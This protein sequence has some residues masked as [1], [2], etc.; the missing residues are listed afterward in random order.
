MQCR[1]S[2]ALLQVV[3]GHAGA[4][5]DREVCGLLFG[6]AERIEDAVPAANVSAHPTDS[7]ELDPQALFAAVRAERMGGRRS[8]GH[9]HSHPNG[10]ASPSPR[11]AAASHGDGR[12]WLII[13]ENGVRAW[14]AVRGGAVEGAFEP[15]ELVVD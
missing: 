12:V 3:L 5:P 1:I 11:D 4:D 2:K 9:Y 14:R 13:A 6:S 7:F 10:S 15:L 8:I